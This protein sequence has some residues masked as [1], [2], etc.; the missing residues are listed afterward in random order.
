M[1]D[2]TTLSCPACDYED[3]SI[4]IHVGQLNIRPVATQKS[5]L[6]M[7]CLIS[8]FEI[9]MKYAR[10]ATDKMRVPAG[11]HTDG[12]SIPPGRW[13]FRDIKEYQQE[14]GTN[15]W[16]RRCEVPRFV[17]NGKMRILMVALKRS[18]YHQLA[19]LYGL[20]AFGYGSPLSRVEKW[21]SR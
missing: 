14:A 9:I 11:F 12:A 18:K 16:F 21:F 19:I 6:P 20:Q 10:H 15:D 7:F 4:Q 1:T 8:D 3:G 5:R 2:G 17:S 13:F